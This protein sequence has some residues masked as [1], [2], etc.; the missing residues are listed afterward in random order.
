M[1]VPVVAAALTAALALPL[2]APAAP[3]A[4]AVQPY[5]TNDAGGFRNVLPPGEAGTD[6]VAQLAAYQA[7]KSRPD[8]WMD[9][10]PLYQNLLYAS[11]GLTHDQIGDFYKDATFGV[12]DGQTDTT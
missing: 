5:S 12:P 9:Q 3:A 6:N 4:A 8:H 10:Q 11:P 7:F 2:A 1:R